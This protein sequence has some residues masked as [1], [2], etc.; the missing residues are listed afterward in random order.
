MNSIGAEIEEDRR[1][2]V[3]L[4]RRMNVSRNPVKQAT[5]W[6][7]E[8]ASLVKFSGLGSGERHQ[9]AFMALETLALGVEGKSRMWKALRQVQSQYPPLAS[10]NL[11]ALIARAETQHAALERERLVAGAIALANGEPS[12]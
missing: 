10:T 9:S 7:A 1:H 11:E 8:K 12:S 4:M 2:L 3:E 6:L 5:G